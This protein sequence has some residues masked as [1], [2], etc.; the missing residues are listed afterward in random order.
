MTVNYTTLLGLGQPVTG[1]E[2]GTW[3]DD[4]NNAITSYLDIAI[5]GTLTLTGDGSVTLANTFGSSVATNIGSTTAQYY[6]LKIVGPLTQNKTITAPSTS[7]TYIVNNTD[8]TY[9]VIVKASGQPGVSISPNSFALIAFNGSD[10]ALVGTSGGGGGGSTIAGNLTFLNNGNR[11]IGDFSNLTVPNR[12][13]FQSNTTNGNTIVGTIPNGTSQTSGFTAFNKNSAVNCAAARVQITDTQARFVSGAEGSGTHLPLVLVTYGYDRV[14]VGV[15]GNVGIGTN[16]PTYLLEANGGVIGKGGAVGHHVEAY[17]AIPN[18][19]TPQDITTTTN[20]IQAAINAA[21]ANTNGSNIVL[22]GSTNYVINDTLNVAM[23]NSQTIELRGMAPGVNAS[24]P[25]QAQGTR[26][27]FKSTTPDAIAVHVQGD[28]GTGAT[29]N[30]AAFIARDLW[31]GVAT[32]GQATGQIGIQLGNTG[33]FWE[34]YN[35][36]F[37]YNVQC[38]KFSGVGIRIVNCQR[39][40]LSKC[41]AYTPGDSGS[42]IGLQILSTGGYFGGGVLCDCCEFTAGGALGNTERA[43]KIEAIGNGTYNSA[44]ASGNMF[45]NTVLYYGQVG[46]EIYAS[47]GGVIGDT[48]LNNFQI[49]GNLIGGGIANPA[50]QHALYI[51][52]GSNPVNDLHTIISGVKI[53]NSY[54]TGWKQHGIYIKGANTDNGATI[55]NV[56]IQNTDVQWCNSHGIKLENVWGFSVVGN[57]LRNNGNSATAFSSTGDANIYVATCQY[58]SIASNSGYLRDNVTNNAYGVFIASGFS[59]SFSIVNN[60]M[61]A[62]YASYANNSTGS[63]K[64][65][66]GNYGG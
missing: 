20:A 12:V 21:K 40:T 1:T 43:V 17:G 2:S 24:D 16:T 3:G 38:F 6:I 48:Y 37:L 56:S 11:I 25:T 7:K 19:T 23:T 46:M 52:T 14:H 8:A 60:S 30:R 39:L 27:T 34:A 49:D 58:F 51:N 41:I 59:D 18:A 44:N 13:M 5:A 22:F 55:R 9:N 64:T 33:E 29:A 31:I 53:N 15:N 57:N 28:Q 42:A 26:I 36:T 47:G 66:S 61:T 62:G 50:L 45:N 35:K 63:N 65:I 4:V 54:F 10:Y 32:V